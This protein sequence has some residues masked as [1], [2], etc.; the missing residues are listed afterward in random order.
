MGHTL[1]NI[2]GATASLASLKR[3]F[4]VSHLPSAVT[5][6]AQAKAFVEDATT[7]TFGS[8][9]VGGGTNKVPV[10]SDGA[11]WKIG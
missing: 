2:T 5:A 3:P 6:G 10:Y 4:L 1:G 11:V 9:V 7:T 8:T